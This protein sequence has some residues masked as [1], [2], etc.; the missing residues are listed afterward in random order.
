MKCYKP[1][2]DCWVLLFVFLCLQLTRLISQI[3][4]AKIEADQIDDASNLDRQTCCEFI[5]DHMLHQYG[6]KQLS[7]A[8]IHGMFKTIK[9]LISSRQIE[10]AHRARICCLLS[11]L[12]SSSFL[13]KE[14]S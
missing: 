8:A 3:Y 13:C 10:K 9:S 4:A 14:G 12:T 1:I 5:Y 6:L 7:E 2:N 11:T